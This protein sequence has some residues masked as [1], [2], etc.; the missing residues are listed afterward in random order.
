MHTYIHYKLYY[1]SYVIYNNTIK[2]TI[3]H[4]TNTN[5]NSITIIN[6]FPTIKL[7]IL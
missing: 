1:F 7:Y 6:I 2:V 4:N 5:T 3:A